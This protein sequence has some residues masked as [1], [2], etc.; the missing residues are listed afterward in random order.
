MS[1]ESNPL[2]DPELQRQLADVFRLEAR[3]RVDALRSH[4]ATLA[5]RPPSP[6]SVL[7]QAKREAHNLKGSAATVGADQIH[8]VAQKLEKQIAALTGLETAPSP[9]ALA[10]MRITFEELAKQVEAAV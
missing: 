4:F 10:A 2:L 9:I 5:T 8:A 6:D 7:L 3:E 1:T